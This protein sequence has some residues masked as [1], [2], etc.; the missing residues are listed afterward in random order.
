MKAERG[1]HATFI[2]AAI[3]YAG[4]TCLIWPYGKDHKGYGKTAIKGKNC[5]A[6]RLVCQA[7]HGERPSLQHWVAHICGNTLCVAPRHLRW[8]TAKENEADKLL[9]DR[10]I[11]GERNAFAMLTADAVRAIRAQPHRPLAEFAQLYGVSKQTVCK[12]RLRQ[13]WKW[14]ED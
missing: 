8:A 7:V 1:Q 2:Q 10:H 4:A 12:A 6:H 11:R 13:T 14:L 9:H 5:L 3:S